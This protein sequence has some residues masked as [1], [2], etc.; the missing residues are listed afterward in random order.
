MIKGEYARNHLRRDTV[1]NIDREKQRNHRGSAGR[2]FRAGVALR[3]Y[4]GLEEEDIPSSIV[5]LVTDLLHLARSLD[6]D[7]DYV[8]WIAQAHF[9]AELKEAQEA[10]GIT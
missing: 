3:A 6:I 4:P 1:D 2:F 5:D 9:K 7:T 10:G 8:Q